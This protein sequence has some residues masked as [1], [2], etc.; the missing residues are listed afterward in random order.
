M[1][2]HVKEAFNERQRDEEGRKQREG[3]GNRK[4]VQILHIFFWTANLKHFAN[5]RFYWPRAFCI[6]KMINASLRHN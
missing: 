5:E 6:L 1:I 4:K 2:D 3:E